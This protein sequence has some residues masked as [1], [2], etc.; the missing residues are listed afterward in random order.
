MHNVGHTMKLAFIL[1]SERNLIRN[2]MPLI[3]G[4]VGSLVSEL[5]GDFM[6][7]NSAGPE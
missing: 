1:V 2:L 6:V 5:V 4:K 7:I 3:A